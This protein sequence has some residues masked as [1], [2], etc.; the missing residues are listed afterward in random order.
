MPTVIDLSEKSFEWLKPKI[1]ACN[2]TA[3]RVANVVLEKPA[4]SNSLKNLF[5]IILPTLIRV[6]KRN[7]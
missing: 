7:Y 3:I 2:K 1:A 6:K 5:L 4:Q